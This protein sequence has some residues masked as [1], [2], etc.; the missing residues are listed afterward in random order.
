MSNEENKKLSP[1]RADRRAALRS[2][3]LVLR[4]EHGGTN[5]FFGYANCLGKLGM[6]VPT[7]NPRKL[8]S[9][10][11][12]SFKFPGDGTEVACRGRVVWVNETDP[13]PGKNPGMGIE[14]L[15]L[16]KGTGDKI[17]EWIKAGCKPLETPKKK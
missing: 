9:E 12:L 1:M 6:G 10:Y 4:V 3:L 11:D 13:E 8:G 7:I 2:G 14:F 17:E 16:D 15:D 5:S